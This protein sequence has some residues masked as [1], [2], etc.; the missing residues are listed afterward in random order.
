MKQFKDY[1]LKI[2][3]PCIMHKICTCKCV[4]KMDIW[5][6]AHHLMRASNSGDFCI[7]KYKRTVAGFS[8]TMDQQETKTF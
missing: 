2:R 5:G 1:T 4:C 6:S 8:K 3:N 7:T